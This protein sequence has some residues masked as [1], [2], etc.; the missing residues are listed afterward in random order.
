[1]TIRKSLNLYH[2]E[3]SARVFLLDLARGGDLPAYPLVLGRRRNVWR[4]RLSELERA[5][6]HNGDRSAAPLSG[7]ASR[8]R[9]SLKAEN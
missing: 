7:R 4:F 1:M 8:V 3:L 6:C 5:R 2:N 9:Q